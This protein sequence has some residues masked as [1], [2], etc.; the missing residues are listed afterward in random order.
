MASNMN[1]PNKRREDEERQAPKAGPSLEVVRKAKEIRKQNVATKNANLKVVVPQ[2]KNW[3]SGAQPTARETVARMYEVANGDKAK[4]Q[5]LEAK[6]NAERGNRGSVIY[7]PYTS[8]TN[9]KELEALAAAG[10]DVSGGITAEWFKEN[11]WLRNHARTNTGYGALAPS[12]KSSALENAA[13]AY[14]NLLD[15]ETR[16]AKAE[17]ELAVMAN[18]AKYWADLGYSD[19]EIVKK[20]KSNKDYGTLWEMDEERQQGGASLLNRAVDYSGEDTMY[21][22]IWAA[23][24]G[25]TGNYFTDSVKY[26]MGQGN[27]YKADPLSEAARDPSNLEGYHPYI[28]GGTRHD[29]NQKYGVTGVDQQWL[30]DHRDWLNDPEK[31]DDWRA[32]ESDFKFTQQAETELT[33]LDQ[34]LANE[35]EKL[36]GTEDARDKLASKLTALITDGEEISYRDANGKPQSIKL[37]N[38]SKMEDK[39]RSGLAE[40]IAYAIDFTLPRYLDKVNDAHEAKVAAQAVPEEAAAEDKGAGFIQKVGGAIDKGLT[41]AGE[42]ADESRADNQYAKAARTG[43]RKGDFGADVQGV[44]NARAG[45]ETPEDVF[46]NFMKNEFGIDFKGSL[47]EEERAIVEK[48]VSANVE[49]TKR[50]YTDEE[51]AAAEE[52]AAAMFGVAQAIA[53]QPERQKSKEDAYVDSAAYTT[54]VGANQQREAEA[55][56]YARGMVEGELTPQAHVRDAGVPGG[57]APTY[58]SG[59]M[60]PVDFNADEWTAMLAGDTSWSGDLFE[61][62]LLT[63]TDPNAVWAELVDGISAQLMGE[64][65]N[66]ISQSWMKEFSGLTRNVEAKH[67]WSPQ[68]NHEL[69][70]HDSRAAY[71]PEIQSALVA[72]EK[73]LDMGAIS[74]QEYVANLVNLSSTAEIVK[75]AAGGRKIN[76]RR[77]A[78]ILSSGDGS[79]GA[80]VA[81]LEAYCNEKIAA[82]EQQQ[83]DEY[84]AMRS[85]I[86]A[87]R[88]ASNAGNA[89][90]GQSMLDGVIMSA[91]VSSIANTDKT[92]TQYSRY[93]EARAPGE[94]SYADLQMQAGD[95][96]SP[97]NT[98]GGYDA[99]YN[100]GVSAL[101]ME[102]LD[103]DMHYAAAL[104]LSL[105]EYY[106]EYPEYAKS[107]EQMMAAAQEEFDQKWQEFGNTP[108]AL[109]MVNEFFG[110]GKEQADGEDEEKAPGYGEFTPIYEDG[111]YFSDIFANATSKFGNDFDMNLAKAKHFFTYDLGTENE[112]LGKLHNKYGTDP[113]ALREAWDKTLLD[114][115]I[116]E[117]I[118]AEI[119]AKMDTAGSIYDLGDPEELV[120]DLDIAEYEQVGKYY[121]DIIAANGNEVEKFVYNVIAAGENMITMMATAQAGAMF[122]VISYATSALSMASSEYANAY[123][124]TKQTGDASSALIWITAALAVGAKIEQL[125]MDNYLAPKAS[126]WDDAILKAKYATAKQGVF[127]TLFSPDGLQTLVKAAGAMSMKGLTNAGGETLEEGSQSLVDSFSK[128][129]ALKDKKFL[130]KEDWKQAGIEAAYGGVLGIAAGGFTG[131]VNAAATDYMGAE[132]ASAE[133]ALAPEADGDLINDAIDFESTIAAIQ[134]S[135][136]QLAALQD[137]PENK[138]AQQAEEAFEAADKEASA[139]GYELRDAKDKQRQA[140]QRLELANEYLAGRDI[141]EDMPESEEEKL[142]RVKIAAEALWSADDVVAAAEAKKAEADAKLEEAR[143]KRDSAREVVHAKYRQIIDDAKR[144]AAQVIADKNYN[145]ETEEQKIAN[146][147]Y[148]TACKE[149]A[150]AKRALQVQRARHKNGMDVNRGRALLAIDKLTAKVEAARA[151]VDKAFE[152]VGEKAINVEQQKDLEAATQAAQKAA[153]EAEADRNNANKQATAELAQARLEAVRLKQEL[154]TSKKYTLSHLN[155]IFPEMRAKAVAE[156]QAKQQAANKAAEKAKALEERYTETDAQR[157][158]REAI[159]EAKQYT[160]EQLLFDDV[161]G[162]AEAAAAYNRVRLAKEALNKEAK[163]IAAEKTEIGTPEHEEAMA[164]YAAAIE[165]EEDEIARQLGTTGDNMRA[166]FRRKSV[167]AQAL[168]AAKAKDQAKTA[169]LVKQVMARGGDSAAASMKDMAILAN[170]V[171]ATADNIAGS[172]AEQLVKNDGNAPKISGYLNAMANAMWGDYSTAAKTGEQT[173]A[174]QSPIEIM[175]NIAKRIGVGFHAGANMSEGGMQMP[176]AVQGFYNK[177]VNA[178]RTATTAASDLANGLHEIGHAVQ[179]RLGDLHATESMKSALSTEVKRTYGNDPILLDGEA[180]AEFVVQYL[181]SRD[182]AVKSVGMEFV[183]QFEDMVGKDKALHKALQDASQQIALWN[184]ATLESK[185]QA[186]QKM[187]M[188]RRSEIGSQLSRFVRGIE[189][190]IF[191]MTAPAK[192]VSKDF[193]QKAL[194][195]MHAINRADVVLSQRLID[196]DGNYVGASLAEALLDAG[197]TKS[198]FQRVITYQLLKHHLA[199][200]AEGKPV[201]DP[202]EYNETAVKAELARMESEVDGIAAGGQAFT[203]WWN[204][205]V[206]TWLVNTGIID[207]K[208]VEAMRAKYENYL[209]TFRV[210]DVDVNAFGGNQSKFQ[211]YGAKKGGSSLDI[212]NPLYSIATQV[213]KVVKYV[214]HNQLMQAFDKE[215][216]RGGLGEIAIDVTERQDEIKTDTT[217]AMELVNELKGKFSADSE[218]FDK[219]INELDRIKSR[220]QASGEGVGKNVVSVVRQDG[221]V[222]YYQIKDTQLFNLLTA[223]QTTMNNGLRVFAATKN[224]ITALTTGSN[225]LFALK[226]MIRDYQASVNTGT[227]A[228]T[229]MDGIVRWMRAFCEVAG[230]SDAFKEWQ[231]MGG[232]EHT[233]MNAA[234][235]ENAIKSVQKQLTQLLL[236]GKHTKD[237]KFKTGKNFGQVLEGTLMAKDF[238]N[239]IEMTSRF[240]EYRFGKHDLSTSEGRQEAFMASQDVTTN[241]GTHGSWAI[242]NTLRQVTPFMNATL[243]GIHKDAQIIADLFSK[244]KATRRKAAPKVAKVALNSML[245]AGLQ[246]AILAMFKKGDKDDEEYAMLNDSMK[247]GN[248]I[249]PMGDEMFKFLSDKYGFSK[250]YWRIPIGQGWLHQ[251]LYAA[252]IETLGDVSGYSPFEMDIMDTVW[253]ILKDSM[254]N[255]ATVFQSFLDARRNKTWYDSPIENAQMERQS[256]YNRVDDDTPNII[257]ETGRFLGTSPAK[258]DYVTQQTAGILYKVGAPLLSGEGFGGVLNAALS[259]FT[260]DPVTG[261]D[262]ANQ[263]YEA[264]TVV[265]ETLADA[266]AGDPLGHIAYGADGAAARDEAEY[267][268]G[269]YEQ[270]NESASIIK[271]EIK[272]INNDP[273]LPKGEKVRRTRELKADLIPV[274]EEFLQEYDVFDEQY[275]GDSK[276][277]LIH[278]IRDFSK[279]YSRP[280]AY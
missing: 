265:S 152:N 212:I 36:D 119:R 260:Y 51:R 178:I 141:F 228:V 224:V 187:Y 223:N 22:M 208:D 57:A 231:A 83:A 4:F 17:T 185:A 148:R 130:T 181:F 5:E 26:T 100:R 33:A 10:I 279:N 192:L 118:K 6:F 261:N 129:R 240:V 209:P 35:I 47:T 169:K 154:D 89:D 65:G 268:A 125:Q 262:T 113:A 220:F 24:N 88:D 242:V 222:A 202:N 49:A 61:K 276:L 258:A 198:N 70:K 153:E 146:E 188:A 204:G 76:A 272:A 147:Q 235:D 277:Q 91:D 179:N 215:Y 72:N 112:K 101:A 90:E 243:Q 193:H 170:G 30:D 11:Q 189:T 82:V 197:V 13:W 213:Q 229:Y 253:S 54:V 111:L 32:Y 221:S 159:D 271:A 87:A 251:S 157:E 230:H 273:D 84:A 131:S 64:E 27:R 16:T 77:S 145:G 175:R 134:T 167:A 163:R 39:R 14:E 34:W 59:S 255:T 234:W 93:L 207:K 28:L 210:Q 56:F 41:A 184:N 25:S 257:A 249:I 183:Q 182:A 166:E 44:F 71:G 245:M 160:N 55:D 140:A 103:R 227:W 85:D 18:E 246:W 102:V 96:N 256:K 252:S 74:K 43:G 62:A 50:D 92:Y 196:P 115:K 40:N 217:K 280:T 3:Y 139:A 144:K 12:S 109:Q 248:L 108:E 7:N 171:E 173:E 69:S 63:S 8:A 238:N 211:I 155:S 66:A 75:S 165:S 99:V 60:P 216:L 214:T 98:I 79:L 158:L 86:V 203:N 254:P 68:V 177:Y 127:K 104:G 151:A 206:D 73:A 237:G 123:E 23:R 164:E 161:E 267:L 138:A 120:S 264:G 162:H 133:A 244:D 42:W 195:T 143:A 200:M 136:E 67:S 218:A 80:G 269:L 194:Y 9:Y 124:Y 122:G 45:A 53:G 156:W 149:L 135:G 150:E 105:D 81:A 250:P 247:A 29:M 48:A 205:F 176:K 201:F 239:I 278:R 31:A 274:Y 241:F 52:A 20:L 168:E 110:I 46:V 78:E 199:R 226:N 174:D 95:P 107:P 58:E 172:I 219:L 266:K 97:A 180:V 94:N 126:K 2:Q 190:G 137:S 15:A 117:N 275:V 191:D 233:R 1:R 21:G 114:E 116:P 121:D 236:Q 142:N 128:H 259:Y 270:A 132:I 106:E 225:L 263:F 37:T 19:N 38:L 186:Q 232:G